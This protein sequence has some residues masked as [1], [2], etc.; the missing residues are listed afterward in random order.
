MAPATVTHAAHITRDSARVRVAII[1]ARILSIVSG[2]LGCALLLLA[3]DVPAS[4]VLLIASAL[5]WLLAGL[6][7]DRIR[8]HTGPSDR[9]TLACSALGVAALGVIVIWSAA[10]LHAPTALGDVTNSVRLFDTLAVSLTLPAVAAWALVHRRRWRARGLSA[11]QALAGVAAGLAGV[12]GHAILL[13]SPLPALIAA[14]AGAMLGAITM[15]S[16]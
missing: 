15:R 3:G 11:V 4:G 16:H 13:G 7:T 14:A 1:T 8:S 6:A 2:V 12:G 5:L 10:T 9:I